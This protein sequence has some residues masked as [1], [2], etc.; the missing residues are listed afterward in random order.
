MEFVNCLNWFRY[1]FAKSHFR[2]GQSSSLDVYAINFPLSLSSLAQLNMRWSTVWSP[3][4][5]A[6]SG[7]WIILNQ[8]RYALV[9]PCAVTIAVKLGDRLIFFFSLSCTSGKYFLVTRP[10]LE[11]SHCCCHF[12]MDFW[13]SRHTISLF[14]ILLKHISLFLAASLASLSASSLPLC[15]VWAS[16]HVNSMCQFSFSRAVVFFLIS[17]IKCFLFFVFLRNARVILG[18][19]WQPVCRTHNLTTFMC[20][21]SWNVGASTSWNPQGLAWPIQGLLYCISS[22]LIICIKFLLYLVF[23]N[24]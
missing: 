12:A 23:R 16:I 5:Q 10:L 14:G 18:G 15:P 3:L 17:S 13:L 19:L 6:H 11:S 8:C 2:T 21:M 1:L 24:W 22:C 7:D 9:F 20:Q 4:A